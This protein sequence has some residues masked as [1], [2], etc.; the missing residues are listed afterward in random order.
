[1][2]N[3]ENEDGIHYFTL[4][5]H[6][7]ASQNILIVHYNLKCRK[8]DVSLVFFRIRK[9]DTISEDSDTCIILTCA[10]KIYRHIDF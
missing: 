7:K 10:I 1:M 2:P 6:K 3:L 9:K 4:L 8:T 5:L